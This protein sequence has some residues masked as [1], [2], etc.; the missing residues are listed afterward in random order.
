MRNVDEG[1]WW[2]FP[3]VN[4]ADIAPTTSKIPAEKKKKKV[5]EMIKNSEPAKEKPISTLIRSNKEINSAGKDHH[6][7]ESCVP[8][9]NGGGLFLKLNYDSVLNAWSDK[10]S[11][12]SGDAPGAESAGGGSD[13]QARLAQIDLFSENGGV[14]EASV[15]RKGKTAYPPLL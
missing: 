10:S 15:L 8:Q 1:D 4:V 13:V 7:E 14:R 3:S 11:P 5:A 12:F 6:K 9:Q 2:R